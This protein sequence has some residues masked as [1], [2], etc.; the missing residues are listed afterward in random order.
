MSGEYGG[1]NG[2]QDFPGDGGEGKGGA[3]TAILGLR[4]ASLL[5]SFHP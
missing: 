3:K 5:A 1:W 2:T 4:S